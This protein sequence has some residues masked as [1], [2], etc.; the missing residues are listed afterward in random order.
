MRDR[1]ERETSPLPKWPRAPL[2]TRRSAAAGAGTWWAEPANRQ[3]RPR[4][5]PL[6]LDSGLVWFQRRSRPRAE[7]PPGARHFRRAGLLAGGISEGRAVAAGGVQG[8][9][10]GPS[11]R[12][13]WRGQRGSPGLF[14]ESAAPSRPSNLRPFSL[15]PARR[16]LGPR[17]QGSPCLGP[18]PPSR[19]SGPGR[20][21]R[22]A[23]SEP[24]FLLLRLP[25]CAE[26]WM[27]RF[28]GPP[29]KPL[30]SF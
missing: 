2:P 8:C 5:P 26:V 23:A 24:H 16:R 20:G 28:G 27:N 19:G 14:P 29:M 1:N 3:V 10:V 11:R 15:S 22:A 17:R 12:Q 4:P 6:S 7:G 9:G 25:G 13:K 18:Q 30:C 21:P